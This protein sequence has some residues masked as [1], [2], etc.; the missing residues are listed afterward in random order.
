MSFNH[1]PAVRK[2]VPL[3]FGIGGASSSGKTFSSLRIATGIQSI[4]GGDIFFIDTEASRALHYADRFK[5]QHVPFSPPF[6]SLRYLEAAEYCVKNGAGVIVIDSM[7]HEHSGIGGCLEMHAKEM[8]GDYK[9]SFTA[10]IK[11]KAER[12]KMLNGLLQ[13]NANFIFCFR[14]KEDATKPGPPGSQPIQIGFDPECGDELTYEMT[15]MCFVKKGSKGTPDWIARYPGEKLLMKVPIQFEGI[16]DKAE[17]LSESMGVKMAQWAKGDSTSVPQI[18][19]SVSELAGLIVNL[20]RDKK[21]EK[22]LWIALDSTDKKFYSDD[23]AHASTLNNRCAD[24]EPVTL[25]FNI[26]SKFNEILTV[27]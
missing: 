25:T 1:S 6:N 27:K 3:W 23:P 17:Q 14:G 13:L 9:K 19:Q 11:P 15:A 2:K 4:A 10:W 22:R 24:Q 7:S 12:R 20:A 18:E 26:A 5:F 21:D 16:I 8:N